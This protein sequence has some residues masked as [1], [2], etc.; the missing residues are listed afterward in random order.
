MNR[1]AAS[2]EQCLT[3]QRVKLNHFPVRPIRRLRQ[4]REGMET[5][6]RKDSV[7][8]LLFMLRS[9]G[10][11]IWSKSGQLYYQAGRGML[12]QE[13]REKLQACRNEIIQ[14]LPEAPHSESSDMPLLPRL[15][16]D[17]PPL[18]PSQQW[19][20]RKFSG[21]DRGRRGVIAMRLF[22]QLN[23]KSLREAFRELPCR[24][25][26]LRTTIVTVSHLFRQR[27]D[28]VGN[29]DLEE[30]DVVGASISE[31][32]A[33][34]KGIIEQLA[35]ETIDV[36]VEPLFVPK[37]LKLGDQD[38]I[39]VMIIHDLICDMTSQNILWQDIWTAY[40][41][42]VRGLPHSLPK[43]PIQLAD[44]ACWYERSNPFWT[45]KHGGYWKDRLS[46]AARVRLFQDE[47]IGKDTLRR[48]EFFWF[49]FGKR[50][51]GDLRALMRRQRTSLGMVILTT[52]VAL[53]LRW[54]SSAD[55]VVSFNTTG[56]LHSEVENTIGRLM[57]P[58]F[59][60]IEILERET[61]LD[62]LAR[63][64]EEYDTAFE[65]YD[66][67][68][69]SA[70]IPEQEF[71]RNPNFNW[72]PYRALQDPAKI[73]HDANREGFVD[74]IRFQCFDHKSTLPDDF[75][76]GGEP[77]FGAGEGE[78]EIVGVIM[79]QTDLVMLSSLERFA[80][81]FRWF[82]ECFAADPNTCVSAI[83]CVQ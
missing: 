74:G 78:D 67:G 65:H 29:L 15:P 12:T 72:V 56:R 57:C 30:V 31:R 73:F 53:M 21:V 4:V 61:F 33:A 63:V 22:G 47:E 44:L 59:L 38:H 17:S 8:D 40:V 43:I 28:E 11:R 13:E 80:R 25:E 6:M 24:H 55:I 18:T 5:Q 36:A 81:N 66:F 42:S 58:L 10:V 16:S 82:A 71:I 23:I 34:A 39:L 7:T 35:V 51:T 69:I 45:D 14:I 68:R 9:K 70:A 49:G 3:T 60:R 77:L 79:Y 64:I 75:L 20:W 76:G 32:E 1:P 48:T 37:L 52:W 50:L 54:S 27:I 2:S 62:L 46:G 83:S 19:W 41:Q 26:S